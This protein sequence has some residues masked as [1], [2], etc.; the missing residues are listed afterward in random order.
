[1]KNLLPLLLLLLT[2]SC[3]KIATI[4]ASNKVSI[5]NITL[6]TSLKL[7]N[8]TNAAVDL[9]NWQL[10][11]VVDYIS[12]STNSFTITGKIILKGSDITFSAAELGFGLNFMYTR[13]YLYD[14]S[15]N[16]IDEH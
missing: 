7:T 11:E 9:N 6:H 14:N 8:N 15:G 1:M 16:L 13:I 5:S 2:V 4:P 3:K 10:K 12:T